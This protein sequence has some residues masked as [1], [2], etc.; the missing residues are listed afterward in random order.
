M[1]CEQV[2]VCVCG[3]GPT[4]LSGIK[5]YMCVVLGWDDGKRRWRWHMCVGLTLWW[6]VPVGRWAISGHVLRPLAR[7]VQCAGW[8]KQSAASLH[9]ASR[10]ARLLVRT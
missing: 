7:M 6:V 2:V 3:G 5:D 4:S 1:G 8:A 10:G 9:Q